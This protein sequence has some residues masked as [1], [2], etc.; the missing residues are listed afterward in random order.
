VEKSVLRFPKKNKRVAIGIE[1]PHEGRISAEYEN[2]S[3]AAA[4][5][6]A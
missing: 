2:G 4:V 6:S 5:S 3:A 1:A